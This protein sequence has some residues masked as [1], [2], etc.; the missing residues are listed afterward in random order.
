MLQNHNECS[1]AEL[2][3]KV[4][5]FILEVWTNFPNIKFIY[6]KVKIVEI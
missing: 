3:V 1:N 2:F 4:E 6:I 5:Q